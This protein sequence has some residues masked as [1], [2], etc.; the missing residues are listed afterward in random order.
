MI[1]LNG[2]STLDVLVS[3]YGLWSPP[4]LKNPARVGFIFFLLFF[5]LT[6]SAK[7]KAETVLPAGVKAVRP[8]RLINHFQYGWTHQYVSSGLVS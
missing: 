5:L 1:P 2:K 6:F 8:Y 7:T 3:K 4:R